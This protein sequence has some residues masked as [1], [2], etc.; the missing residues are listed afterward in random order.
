SAISRG[1]RPSAG[2]DDGRSDAIA[3]PWAWRVSADR[4]ALSTVHHDLGVRYPV[5]L[6]AAFSAPACRGSPRHHA[7]PVC[8]RAGPSRAWLIV[9][10]VDGRIVSHRAGEAP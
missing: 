1:K 4:L 7:E 10:C 6:V 2:P 8:D 5:G 9:P 3:L